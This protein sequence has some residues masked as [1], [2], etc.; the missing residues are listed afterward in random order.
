MI[1]HG[2]WKKKERSFRDGDMESII[3]R[4]GDQERIKVPFETAR[5]KTWIKILSEDYIQNK[6]K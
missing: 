6:L 5:I 3:L 4:P 1:Y 2:N